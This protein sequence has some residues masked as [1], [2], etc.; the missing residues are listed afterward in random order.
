[1]KIFLFILL[2]LFIGAFFII[3]NQEIRLN[4]SENIGL[5]LDEYGKWMDNLFGNGKVVVGY[6]AKMEWLPGGHS[7]ELEG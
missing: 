2:F 3:S 7:L 6:V 4:N 1:M 5:F